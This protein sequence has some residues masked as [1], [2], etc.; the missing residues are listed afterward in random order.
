MTFGFKS[1]LKVCFLINFDSF[2]EVF[3][4]T[5]LLKVLLFCSAKFFSVGRPRKF[6]LL[7][8]CAS[9]GS[10]RACVTTF[11]S[12]FVGRYTENI[13]QSKIKAPLYW[14]SPKPCSRMA[15]FMMSWQIFKLLLQFSPLNSYLPYHS[16]QKCSFNGLWDL[17]GWDY[18]P[19]VLLDILWP[20]I[21]KVFS[22]NEGNLK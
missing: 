2:W 12:N 10:H 11:K 5:V 21:S 14:E 8:L 15:L 4:H 6:E 17:R 1:T 3:E 7:S 19:E 16:G 18:S 22:L 13:Q 9:K 20:K